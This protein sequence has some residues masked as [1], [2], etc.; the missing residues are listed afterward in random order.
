M[1]NKPYSQKEYYKNAYISVLLDMLIKEFNHIESENNILNKIIRYL[2]FRKGH[3]E[4]IERAF[5]L[6]K[7]LSKNS[8]DD[9]L[10]AILKQISQKLE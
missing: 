5:Q 2:S 9:E 7:L 1:Y 4:Y 3:P 10:N 8:D 6:L